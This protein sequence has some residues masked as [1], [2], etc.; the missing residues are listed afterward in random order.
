M[1]WLKLGPLGSM[2]PVPLPTFPRGS[3]T[4]LEPF[5][6]TKMDQDLQKLIDDPRFRKYH[7]E[8]RRRPAD[9]TL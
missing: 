9:E 1:I 2:A 7:A 8:T 3:P 4:G 6:D 5:D